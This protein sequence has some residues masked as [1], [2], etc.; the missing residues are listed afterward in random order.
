M[1]QLLDY[2]ALEA[3]GGEGLLET[4]LTFLRTARLP[5]SDIWIWSFLEPDGGDNAYA[6]VAVNGITEIGYET[7]YH[8]L[9]TEQFL[10]AIQCE[11]F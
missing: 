8:G 11:C 3:P 9:K 6:W 5:R 2:L 4:D 10:L 7:D 1:R